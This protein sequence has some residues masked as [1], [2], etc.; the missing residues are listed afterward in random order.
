MRL[1][2]HLWVCAAMIAVSTMSILRAESL[3]S[4]RVTHI[5]REVQLMS[6][7][8][9]R[10]AAVS[11]EVRSSSAVRTGDESRAELTF[12]DL[13][14]TRLGANTIFSFNEGAR[15]LTLNRGAILVSIPRNSPAIKV[16]TAAVS[17][18]ITGGTAAMNANPGAPT[19]LFVLE[20]HGTLCSKKTGECQTAAGGEFVM[21]MPNGDITTPEE[22]NAQVLYA[23]SALVADFSVLPNADL[24]QEVIARQQGGGQYTATWP[25]IPPY[26]YIDMSDVIDQAFAGLLP[27]NLAT[28]PAFSL[29]TVTFNAAAGNWSSAGNWKP[30]V[31]PNNSPGK[32]FI[33]IL[34]SGA[35][36]QDIAAG[37]KLQ[38][39]RI[40]GGTLVLSNPI[41]LTNGFQYS[42]GSIGA[43]STLSIF[44][45]STQSVTLMQDGPTINNH[46]VYN[47]TF[48]NADVFMGAGTFNNSGT[49]N[50]TIG[51]NED[52]ILTPF[53]NSGTVSV[54]NGGLAF[55]GGGTSKGGAFT[56][57]SGMF[58]DFNHDYVFTGGTQFIGSDGNINFNQG[59]N[60]MLSGSI[61]NA[62]FVNAIGT[63]QPANL[64]LA[65]D[66]TWSGGG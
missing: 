4:A 64:I 5:I 1:E 20:G 9:V 59:T 21:A 63:A 11:D 31:V 19:K 43:T 12:R 42:G 6:G 22:F 54:L 16:S 47:V 48:D 17:A 49:F 46:G 30:T 44:G 65:G 56:V 60:M 23:S 38:Q 55:A 26:Q 37:V 3:Q 58:I 40:S 18:G 2:R 52:T 28:V 45:T 34:S 53:N 7:A 27:I 36:T 61:T 39:F 33:A 13:T 35:V 24:I 62:S 51:P 25:P 10:P 57:A 14:I 50:K 66:T 32:N 29:T 15:E 41:T 8:A